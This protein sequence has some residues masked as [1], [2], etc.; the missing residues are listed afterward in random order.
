MNFFIIDQLRN[1]KYTKEGME[2]KLW[3]SILLLN[4]KT[5]AEKGLFPFPCKKISDGY[6]TLGKSVERFLS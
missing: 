2:F 4:M 6:G 5:M 3:F 1:Y